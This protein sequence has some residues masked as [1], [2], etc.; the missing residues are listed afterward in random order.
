MT[1]GQVVNDQYKV[2]VVVDDYFDNCDD[3]DIIHQMN[4]ITLI[5]KMKLLST[6][7]GKLSMTKTIKM[8]IAIKMT[9]T[10]TLT[11]TKHEEKAENEVIDTFKNQYKCSSYV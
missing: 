1:E 7:R 10:V 8:M 4:M 3:V 2:F 6:M 11:I 9:R 5:M